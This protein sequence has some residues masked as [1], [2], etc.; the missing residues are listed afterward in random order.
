MVGVN[1]YHHSQ[2]ELGNDG[3]RTIL[4]PDDPRRRP[5][6]ELVR[7]V[8]ER[9]HRPQTLLFSERDLVAP[10]RS[11]LLR[12]LWAQ[13]DPLLHFLLVHLLLSGARPAEQAP[14]L[15]ELLLAAPDVSDD[16]EHRALALLRGEVPRTRV[17]PAIGRRPG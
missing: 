17:L 3:K 6:G 2:A 10:G 11:D 16:D 5:V 7:R 4:E 12:D 14:P 15:D 8:W 9:Y 13:P 1:V